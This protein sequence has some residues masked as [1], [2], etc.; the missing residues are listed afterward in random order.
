[1]LNPRNVECE[2]LQGSEEEVLANRQPKSAKPERGG[3]PLFSDAL[4]QQ[5]PVENEQFFGE[6]L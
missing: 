1:M 2:S 5:P 6:R 3:V 4:D